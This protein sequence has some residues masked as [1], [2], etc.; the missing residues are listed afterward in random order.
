[1]A[2]NSNSG[3]SLELTAKK[4]RGL[5]QTAVQ[6][7][8]LPAPRLTQCPAAYRGY[9]TLLSVAS[10]LQ[11]L[12]PFMDLFRAFGA[13]SFLPTLPYARPPCRPGG[14]LRGEDGMLLFPVGEFSLFLTAR[15]DSMYLCTNC[16]K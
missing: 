13:A 14:L 11:F 7:R 9:N 12:P 3:P 15:K 5:V 4:F 6:P 10:T 1:M 8:L 2:N 16:C